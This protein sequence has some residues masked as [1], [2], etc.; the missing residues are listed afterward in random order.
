MNTNYD[1]LSLTFHFIRN[2]VSNNPVNHVSLAE[3][4][5]RNQH[6]QFETNL[7][8]KF[9]VYFH[10]DLLIL[11]YISYSYVILWL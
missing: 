7:S 11:V 1:Q 2:L 4:S 10:C 6:L 3:E 5:W 9:K 8:K